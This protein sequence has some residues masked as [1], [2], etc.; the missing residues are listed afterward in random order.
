MVDSIV[1]VLVIE[2]FI[3]T[4]LLSD[5]N[6]KPYHDVLVLK[7]VLDGFKEGLAVLG[8]GLSVEGA[9]YH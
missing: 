7:H 6:V 1:E 3:L 9:Q 8:A 5:P 4:I 2:L